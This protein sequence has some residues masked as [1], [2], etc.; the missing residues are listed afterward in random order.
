MA[1]IKQQPAPSTELVPLTEGELE[2]TIARNLGIAHVIEP[3]DSGSDAPPRRRW[4]GR[5]DGSLVAGRANRAGT[6][7][8]INRPRDVWPWLDRRR[9]EEREPRQKGTLLL[10][11]ASF[12][13]LLLAA[14]QGYVSWF[15]QFHFVLAA[16]HA[17]VPSGI[18]GTGLDAAAVIF[19]FL[20]I[21]LARLGRRAIVP[22]IL[23]VSC[24][25]GSLLMN[26]LAGDL[27][28]PRSLAIF[29]LPS[30]LYA[31][32]SDQLIAVIRRH[33]LPPKDDAE[34]QRSAWVMAWRATVRVT[35]LIALVTAWV[36]RLPLYVIR[37]TVAPGETFGGLRQLVLDLTPLPE[38]EQ[39]PAI[40]QDTRDERKDKGGGGGDRRRRRLRTERTS[41]PTK[42]SVLLSLYAGHTGFGDRTQVTEIARAIAPKASLGEG[43]ARAYIYELLNTTPAD[44]LQKV[45]R[46]LTEAGA[47]A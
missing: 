5:D 29:A 36:L 32:A 40:E 20:A 38:V 11:I 42:K 13:V 39:A 30:V 23:N 22:R 37:I 43:T 26:V 47:T 45:Q 14:G 15:A 2:A 12:L 21:V 41:G 3:A 44:G 19:A 6:M 27:M 33:A 18:E 34:E 24:A 25:A 28:S 9:D 46:E 10:V 7:L 31:T 35:C 17:V 1:R 16:K 8:V 4:W